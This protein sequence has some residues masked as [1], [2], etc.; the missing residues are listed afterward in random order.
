[1]VRPPAG[2]HL[3]AGSLPA[4]GSPTRRYTPDPQR[5]YWR[6]TTSALHAGASGQVPFLGPFAT[7][8]PFTLATGPQGTGEK[9]LVDLVQVQVGWSGNPSP[10]NQPP[11][12]VQQITA[13]VIGEQAAPAPPVVAQVWMTAG[14]Q[15]VHLLA[16]T[17]Q[18]TSDN[19]S[20]ASPWLSAGEGIAVV[21][22]PGTITGHPLSAAFRVRGTKIALTV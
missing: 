10:G 9:W 14:G 21:W 20:V 3:G 12:V 1:M 22:Y 19:L 6:Q 11:Q 8:F 15:N 2:W 17:T 4:V 7:N 13:Q 5:E 18:G 16:Q